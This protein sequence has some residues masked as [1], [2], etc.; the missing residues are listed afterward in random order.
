MDRRTERKNSFCLIFSLGFD[1][2]YDLQDFL[3]NYI[4]YQNIELKEKNKKFIWSLYNGTHEKLENIDKIISKNLKEW[5]LN[6]LNKVDLAIL[7]LAVFE[8]FFFET[9]EKVAINEA[10]ELAK[11]YSSDESPSFINGVLAGLVKK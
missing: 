8:I 5:S 6:R 1:H 11:E 9:P 10:L 2:Q 3:D 7:R 4:E